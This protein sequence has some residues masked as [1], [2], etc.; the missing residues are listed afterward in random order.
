MAILKMFVLVFTMMTSFPIVIGQQVPGS[1]VIVTKEIIDKINDWEIARLREDLLKANIN[2][3]RDDKGHTTWKIFRIRLNSVGS[4]TAH[5]TL[6]TGSF[7]WRASLSN[8]KLS[9][10]WL[11]R[12]DD[13]WLLSFGD[14]GSLGASVGMASISINVRPKVSNGLQVELDD[15]SAHISS[16]DVRVHGSLLSWIYDIII[17]EFEEEIQRLLEKELCK[18]AKT[19]MSKVKE[20]LTNLKTTGRVHVFHTDFLVDYNILKVEVTPQHIATYHGLSVSQ[21]SRSLY[22]TEEVFS[23]ARLTSGVCVELNGYVFNNILKLATELYILKFVFDYKQVI[24]NKNKK[25]AYL[26]CDESLSSICIGTFLPEAKS[27]WPK[28]VAGLRLLATSAKLEFASGSVS[29]RLAG[30]LSFTA[31]DA[32]HVDT[33]FSAAVNVTVP[34]QVKFEDGNLSPRI[35][36]ISGDVTIDQSHIGKVMTPVLKHFYDV[37]PQIIIQAL[38]KYLNDYTVSFPIE[39]PRDVQFKTSYVILYS[40]GIGIEADLC[41]KGTS[42]CSYTA[43]SSWVGDHLDGKLTITDTIE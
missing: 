31:E 23:K 15:C 43:R 17:P 14:D 11:Y 33:M 34:I 4:L 24:A 16:L 30:R 29:L 10:D 20:K 39:L 38:V 35:A 13:G 37:S 42:G 36:N 41:E 3:I 32:T 21:G 28:R 22:V 7:T 25:N 26:S 27:R 2:E 6:G 1:R 19:S 12:H 8:I 5:V 9:A 40:T 18:A